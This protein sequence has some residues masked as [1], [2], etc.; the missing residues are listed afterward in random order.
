MNQIFKPS[1]SEA[2]PPGDP[3]HEVY[4]RGRA[5]WDERMGDAIAREHSWKL[6]F[7]GLLGVLAVSTAGNVWQGAQSKSQVVHVLHDNLGS[8]ISVSTTQGRGGEPSQAQFGAALKEWVANVRS[9]YTDAGALKRN[10]TNAYKLIDGGSPAKTGLDEFFLKVRPAFDYA[11]TNIV[12][13]DQQAALPPPSDAGTV[14]PRTWRLEWRETIKDRTGALV[15]NE[16]WEMNITWAY[17]PQR[18]ADEALNNPNGIHISAF[19]WS[20]R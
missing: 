9:V 1:A 8:V 3:L 11:R 14:G 6:G 5:E 13:I 12:E 15:G 16:R 2:L 7:F 18:T 20:K 19:S 17:L 4:R 10:I